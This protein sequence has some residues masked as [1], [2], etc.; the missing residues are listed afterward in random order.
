MD[1]HW[2]DEDGK[3]HPLGPPPCDCGYDPTVMADH[4]K[5]CSKRKWEEEN[6]QA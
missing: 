2:W 3:P 4:A 6:G 5:W 1:W